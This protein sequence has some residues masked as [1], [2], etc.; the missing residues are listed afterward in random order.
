MSNRIDYAALAILIILQSLMLASLYTLTEPHPPLT[1]PLFALAPFLS[2]SIALAAAA[3]ILGPASDRPGRA[4][5]AVA[6]ITALVSFGPHKWLD[7]AIALIW[8][9]VALAQIACAVL[10]VRALAP[11]RWSRGEAPRGNGVPGASG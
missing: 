3:A 10:L 5:C 2:A 6:A 8:P 7:P 4:V 9:A 11:G 1:I